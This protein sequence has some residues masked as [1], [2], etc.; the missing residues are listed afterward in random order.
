[1]LAGC[2]SAPNPHQVVPRPDK[3][4]IVSTAPSAAELAYEWCCLVGPA[5]TIY[6][7]S[8]DGKEISEFQEVVAVE[9]GYRRINVACSFTSVDRYR[10]KG[11]ETLPLKN[12]VAG[13]VYK[14]VANINAP[15]I[16]ACK[17]ELIEIGS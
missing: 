11:R 2:V 3:A 9:P 15:A 4:L 10:G 8:V 12:L 5:L 16:H 13:R 17:P 14:L 1:M 6:V 7:A